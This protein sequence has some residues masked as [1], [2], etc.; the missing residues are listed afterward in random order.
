MKK[1]KLNYI[2]LLCCASFSAY[3]APC[4]F[5]A[6]KNCT[7]QRDI[8]NDIGPNGLKYYASTNYDHRMSGEINVYDVNLVQPY[9]DSANKPGQIKFLA[10]KINSGFWKS[11]EIMTRHNLHLAPFNSPVK[12]NTWTT[13]EIKHG[14]VEV[15]VKMPKCDTSTDGRC[16]AGTQ[17]N[18]YQS[19]L[20]P[21]IWMMPT[22]D[23]NWPLN[24]EIDISEAYLRG[25]D[26]KTSTGAVH[27]N[28]NSPKC[29]GNDCVFQG[30]PFERSIA[31]RELWKDFHTWGFEWEPDPASTKGGSIINGYFDNKKV[32]GPLRTDTLPADGPGALQRGFNDPNGGYYLIVNLALGGGYA[33]APNAQMQTSSMYV[34]SVKS[35]T[36]NG[37]T[38]PSPPGDCKPPV[39]I[40]SMYSPDKK[41]I[42]V[43]W[44]E[45]TNSAPIQNYQVADWNNRVMW[46][47]AGPTIRV[48]QDQTLPGSNGNFVYF[49]STVCKES[50]SAAV[51]YSVNVTL[52]K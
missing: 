19:G 45:P 20:W 28:G 13:K 27:F 48:F 41:Q 18:S 14:Y 12:S 2:A 51:K 47:G 22:N 25:T 6:A 33:G 21:A 31:A 1:F 43:A 39:N 40:Q 44:M 5:D 49:I 23:G 46:K 26:Y 35:Y 4:A 9:V 11:G 17:P 3:A 24:A 50:T 29:G 36:V 32:W 16:Q 52:K 37:D 8:L 15:V 38:P 42:T 10:N 7:V 30:Y 34:Q